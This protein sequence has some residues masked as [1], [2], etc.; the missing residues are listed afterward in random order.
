MVRRV[1]MHQ[2]CKIERMRMHCCQQIKDSWPYRERIAYIKPNPCHQQWEYFG[3]EITVSNSLILRSSP[4]FGW[5]SFS[6]AELCMQSFWLCVFIGFTIP[7]HRFATKAKTVWAILMENLGILCNLGFK[8]VRRSLARS[9]MYQRFYVNK[10]R[11][12]S[13]GCFISFGSLIVCWPPTTPLKRPIQ[14]IQQPFYFPQT[15][16]D[17]KF[18]QL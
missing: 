13:Y 18:Y 16:S 11:R 6:S 3:A 15:E 1:C 14:W 2:T 9:I 17:V 8:C 10:F 5:I 7:E 4:N 12:I